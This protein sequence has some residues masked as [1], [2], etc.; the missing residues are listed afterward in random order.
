MH[1]PVLCSNNHTQT[2]AK[3]DRV[4]EVSKIW[5]SCGFLRIGSWG[6]DQDALQSPTEVKC[7]LD[8]RESTP[9]FVTCLIAQ[10]L[11][12]LFVISQTPTSKESQVLLETSALLLAKGSWSSA[13]TSTPSPRAAPKPLFC[14][15]PAQ[16]EPQGLSRGPWEGWLVLGHREPHAVPV[17]WGLFLT[18]N[19]RNTPWS[20]QGAVN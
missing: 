7:L 19:K 5:S 17:P 12:V 20:S 8:I 3:P 16:K 4:G 18:Q 1:L 10:S 9:A 11:L 2:S 15:F 13:S 6:K 14:T